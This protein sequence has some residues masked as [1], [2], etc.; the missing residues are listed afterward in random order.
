MMTNTKTSKAKQAKELLS[1]AC[2]RWGGVELSE[3]QLA[4]LAESPSC[5][6]EYAER[7]LLGKFELGEPAIAKSAKQ[8]F[9]YAKNTLYGR[10]SLGEKA[11][12]ENA[13][14]A[15]R[16]AYEVV[17]KP[18]PKGEDAIAQD[19]EQALEYAK[20]VLQGRF[21]KAEA[22][23]L[24]DPLIS[25]QYAYSVIDGPWKEAEDIIGTCPASAYNYAM[26]IGERFEKGEDALATETYKAVS[27][28]TN[29]TKERF[30]KVENKIIEEYEKKTIGFVH[31]CSYVEKAMRAR[32]PE[33]E[34]KLFERNDMDEFCAYGIALAN[35]GVEV[36]EEIN[37]VILA[38]G[39]VDKEFAED[40]VCSKTEF[41]NKRKLDLISHLSYEELKEIINR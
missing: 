36:P 22:E 40:Y 5:A 4:I 16:Y 17:R 15:F 32:W 11:I 7:F 2:S 34:E 6:R 28:A 23:I 24:K 8:S 26:L 10:F 19:A 35:A 20:R 3:E 33:L 14:Y 21:Q 31:I 41:E 39:M 37:N 27:Y 9:L 1:M 18:W 29:I 30:E 38:Y 12:S 13:A 25:Y